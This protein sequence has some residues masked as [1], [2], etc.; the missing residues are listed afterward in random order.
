MNKSR[1]TL[2]VIV[3]LALVSFWDWQV[4]FTLAAIGAGGKTAYEHRVRAARMPSWLPRLPFGFELR[5]MCSHYHGHP[6]G[7]AYGEGPET[8]YLVVPV[9]TGTLPKLDLIHGTWVQCW[10]DLSHLPD[11]TRIFQD[12]RWMPLS[13]YMAR[14]QAPD[15]FSRSL[16]EM[17]AACVPV[18]ID[19]PEY[20]R[21]SFRRP[22]EIGDDYLYDD[23]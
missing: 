19:D 8:I 11:G 9:G 1:D 13:E 21:L 10:K 16:S 2:L 5:E 22:G 18:D 3:A 7:L 23:E 4:G 6:A 20:V 17:R 14:Y 12:K 15:S